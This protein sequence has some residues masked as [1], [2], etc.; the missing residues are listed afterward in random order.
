MWGCGCAW[1]RAHTAGS[2]G[3][4]QPCARGP[5]ALASRPGNGPRRRGQKRRR[6]EAQKKTTGWAQEVETITGMNSLQSTRWPVYGVSGF[7][8]QAASLLRLKR[9]DIPKTD[10]HPRGPAGISVR[11]CLHARKLPCQSMVRTT[12][13]DGKCSGF[14]GP[15]TKAKP[16]AP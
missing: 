5:V 14:T 13:K 6:R 11:R 1:E 7:W 16:E 2:Q 9:V 8:S 15:C 10:P 12:V 4:R 3:L